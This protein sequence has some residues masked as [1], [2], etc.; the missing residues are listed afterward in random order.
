[1]RPGPKMGQMG[2]MAPMEASTPTKLAYTEGSQPH[3]ATPGRA[4]TGA[5]VAEGSG[6]THGFK[7]V[8][9]GLNLSFWTGGEVGGF[10]PSLPA[11]ARSCTYT[12]IGAPTKSCSPPHAAGGAS[13][14]E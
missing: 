9:N 12:G 2:Q 1:M 11:S 6:L 7:A 5:R 10:H 13:V 14:K 8:S 3:T 4:R